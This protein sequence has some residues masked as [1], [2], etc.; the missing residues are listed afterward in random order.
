ML[1]LWGICRYIIEDLLVVRKYN[2]FMILKFCFEVSVDNF[3]FYLVDI[4]FY[5]LLFKRICDW[6]V[7]FL[8]LG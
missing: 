6:E 3:C 7:D 1:M 2:V 4:F 5:I 8:E